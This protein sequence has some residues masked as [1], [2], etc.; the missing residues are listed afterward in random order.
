MSIF[1]SCLVALLLSATVTAQNFSQ[2]NDDSIRTVRQRM[3]EIV[4]TTAEG[5]K[6]EGRGVILSR[7]GKVLVPTTLLS[8]ATEVVVRLLDRKEVQAEG[9][10]GQ[11]PVSGIA[12]IKISA[13]EV[14]PFRLTS[15]VNW[16]FA[17]VGYVVTGLDAAPESTSPVLLQQKGPEGSPNLGPDS[18]W[19]I[20]GGMTPA[21]VGCPVVDAV[22]NLLGV[23]VR[24]EPDKG[25]VGVRAL[26]VPFALFD[27]WTDETVHAFGK[28]GTN[29]LPVSDP[30]LLTTPE[31]LRFTKSPPSS[32][33][34]V[35]AADVMLKARDK[36]PLAWWSAA[37]T[38]REAG[39]LEKARF[40]YAQV[41]ELQP[42]VWQA[43]MALGVLQMDRG[44]FNPAL[45]AF[46][47]VVD[48][49]AAGSQAGL[50]SLRMG[51]CLL[52]LGQP[53][54]ATD[55]FE[56]AVTFKKD[57]FQAWLELGRARFRD[58]K[59]EVAS[60]AFLNAAQINPHSL[61]GWMGLAQSFRELRKPESEVDA[62][63]EIARMKPNDPDAIYD[64][65]LCLNKLGKSD[66]AM[67]LF[68]RVVDLNPRDAESWYNIGVLR[69]KQKDV[70]GALQC[71][72]KTVEIKPGFGL[73]WRELG[74][75][76]A[77]LK[78]DREA[79]E[80]LRKASRLLPTEPRIWEQLAI[81]EKNLGNKQEKEA[82]LAQLESLSPAQAQQLKKDF[83]LFLR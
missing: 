71:Y 62:R 27:Q 37:E 61:E 56:R 78:H 22:G 54:Q 68:E 26:T 55:Q 43:W 14:F 25:F 12:V 53:T 51:R 67:G 52:Q 38:Y 33:A 30:A 63:G 6:R 75:L 79:V 10:L 74:I 29:L 35:A 8:G 83:E 18:F 59:Y 9:W 50:A 42:D 41:T 77:V 81:V 64:Y 47:H 60:Q 15:G 70:T 24:I 28:E 3:V 4:V 20:Q 69:E 11:D 16:K 13:M 58:K 57:L 76:Q 7:D 80:P 21:Q 2:L 72:L 49:G 66:M 23:V 48:S 1:R 65:A 32:P 31:W 17:P 73:G 39:Q 82:A 40:S 36:S 46:T 34:R 19:M 5:T 45:D 44:Q